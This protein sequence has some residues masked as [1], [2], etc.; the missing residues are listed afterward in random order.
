MSKIIVL[1]G[2][3]GFLG[4][5]LCHTLVEAGYT[6]HGY[7][8]S[9]SDLTRLH[10]LAGCIRWHRLPEELEVPF[11]SEPVPAAVIHCAG[12]Y[13]RR[14]ESPEQ[15]REV[16]VRLPLR[17]WKLAAD[18]G[19]PSFLHTDTILDPA[20]NEYAACKHEAAE[21]LKQAR[22][23]TRVTNLRAQHFYGPGDDADKFIPALIAQCLANVPEIP[24]TEG[25]QRRDF[26]FMDDVA[27][28]FLAVLN[29]PPSAG[30]AA[31]FD[32]FEI[33]SGEAVELRRLAAQIR[34]LTGSRS[35]L[36]FGALP[37]RANEPMF[38]QADTTALRALGWR[39]RVPLIEGLRRTVQA[40]M[41]EGEI[42]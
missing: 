39:P 18:S 40:A 29:R 28:A 30:A 12:A 32:E 26:I 5:R 37:Y 27:S 17:L 6:V 15:M 4:S 3:T 36:L 24:L 19:V 33:G 20:L 23:P 21:A 41:P 1:T 10:G 38:T 25:R 9:S 42:L 8:R 13:G 11:R 2:A 22:G 35:R 34:Q 31:A 14:G 7:R 16:N